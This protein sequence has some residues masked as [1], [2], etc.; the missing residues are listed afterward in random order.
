MLEETS[1]GELHHGQHCNASP[2]WPPPFVLAV[3]KFYTY[4]GKGNKFVAEAVFKSWKG[5]VENS[6][7]QF[8]R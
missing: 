7:E 2:P 6:A 8:I 4:H 3:C 1:I 5:G